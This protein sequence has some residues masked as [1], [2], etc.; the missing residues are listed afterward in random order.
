MSSAASRIQRRR[1]RRRRGTGEGDGAVAE[2][3]GDRANSVLQKLQASIEGGI[4]T[5]RCRFTKHSF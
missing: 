3:D 1:R 5:P 2:G 4:S